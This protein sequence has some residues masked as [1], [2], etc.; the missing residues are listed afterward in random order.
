VYRINSLATGI[1][2]STN[3]TLNL[4]NI[5]INCIAI[6]KDS[7]EG[8]Y[9][10]T[11]VGVFYKDTAMG[12]WESLNTNLPNVV[13][14]EL[15]INQKE[16]LLYAATFGRGVWKTK[17]NIDPKLVG[18]VIKSIE[19]GDNSSKIHPNSQLIIY[20]NEPVKKG[21]GTI[22]ILESGIEK[23]RV[24]VE[25]DSVR[26]EEGNKIVVTPGP[27]TLGKSVVVKFPKGTFTDLDGN[28]HKGILTNTEWNFSITTDA[29]VSA[30]NTE[31][32]A[33]VSPNP[34]HGML[35][36]EAMTGFTME[37]IV[38]YNSMGALVIDKDCLDTKHCDINLE[39]YSKGIYNLVL[40]INGKIYS[41]RL[42]VE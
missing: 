3:L 14:T 37:R 18:P 13:V 34:T 6:D 20:F 9:I 17:I 35:N 23:Q 10:G 22:S 16:R 33:R 42:V 41:Q 40:Q 8:L 12:A 38:I 36:I 5:A 15:E 30:L 27:F 21:Y 24:N 28:D 29:K 1:D 4:P 2:K 19:P 7:K 31:M 26:I 11:D 32:P 25:K 39:T